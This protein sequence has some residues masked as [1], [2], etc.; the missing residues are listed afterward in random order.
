MTRDQQTIHSLRSDTGYFGFGR[1]RLGRAWHHDF[2]G[3]IALCPML[4][5]TGYSHVPSI[6]SQVIRHC[7]GRSFVDSVRPTG[8]SR[9]EIGPDLQPR[10]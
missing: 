4:K 3:L 1:L 2:M 10:P 5:S 8:R 7:P 6:Q 9:L